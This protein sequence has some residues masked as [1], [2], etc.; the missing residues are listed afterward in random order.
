[1][2]VLVRPRDSDG[3]GACDPLARPGRRPLLLV[4]PDAY[5]VGRPFGRTSLDSQPSNPSLTDGGQDLALVSPRQIL[6]R[7]YRLLYV[8]QIGATGEHGWIVMA[9]SFLRL[10]RLLEKD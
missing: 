3:L 4:W 5:V 6:P 10:I 8:E 1:M 9:S 2:R 7:F